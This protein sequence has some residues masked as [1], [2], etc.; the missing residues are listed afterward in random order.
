MPNQINAAVDV[1]LTADVLRN[2]TSQEIVDMF[3]L[4]DAGCIEAVNQS[5]ALHMADEATRSYRLN[6]TVAS[7][8]VFANADGSD[9]DF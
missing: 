3:A 7:G 4:S 2:L 5:D 6:R 9:F 8:S 1:T